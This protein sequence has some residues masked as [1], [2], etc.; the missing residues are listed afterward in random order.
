MLNFHIRFNN[1]MSK[2]KQQL[3][4][5]QT[6]LWHI[7]P[8]YKGRE[9]TAF[10]HKVMQKNKCSISFTCY[11]T[12]LLLCTSS[13]KAEQ[14]EHVQDIK[15][16]YLV[17]HISSFKQ[18]LIRPEIIKT[19]LS[20]QEILQHQMPISIF[21]G[22]KEEIVRCCEWGGRGGWMGRQNIVLPF[23]LTAM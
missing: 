11:A 23:L 22:A 14:G 8:P 6:T 9:Y 5:W 20:S 18:G 19:R 2:L 12:L 15:S 1:I 4:G 10:F 16:L 21:V 13:P 7:W 3:T 17:R